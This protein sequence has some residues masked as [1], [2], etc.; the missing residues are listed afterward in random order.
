ME[1]TAINPW[2]WSLNLGYN[3]GEVITGTSRQL[4][5]T[6][7]TAVDPGGNPQHEGDMRAQIAFDNLEAETQNTPC[8]FQTRPQTP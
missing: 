1:R 7:Q 4:N 5:C 8:L 3:Q 6:G 2:N